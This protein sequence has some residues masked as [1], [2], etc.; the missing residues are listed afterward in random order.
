MKPKLLGQIWKQVAQQLNILNVRPCP[1]GWFPQILSWIS[2]NVANSTTKLS[3]CIPSGNLTY[4]TWQNGI[5]PKPSQTQLGAALLPTFFSYVVGSVIWFCGPFQ[6]SHDFV[7]LI[8]IVLHFFMTFA[9]RLLIPATCRGSRFAPARYRQ[10]WSR[11]VVPAGVRSQFP[12]LPGFVLYYMH[13][14]VSSS[15]GAMRL[16]A[17]IVTPKNKVWIN[18]PH[19]GIRPVETPVQHL[20]LGVQMRRTVDLCVSVITCKYSADL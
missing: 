15:P 20:H 2:M 19:T 4:L 6:R 7:Q 10:G 8:C 16:C 9:S 3:K 1:T 14:L 18:C 12:N 11:L 13:L 5:M 17:R